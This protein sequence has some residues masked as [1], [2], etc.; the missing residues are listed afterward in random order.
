MSQVLNVLNLE[1]G[2]PSGS[3]SLG[4]G[5]SGSLA[6]SAPTIVFVQDLVNEVT[7]SVL[8][9]SGSSAGSGVVDEETNSSSSNSSSSP[10]RPLE[11]ESSKSSKRLKKS[12][13]AASGSSLITSAPGTGSKL[14]QRLGGILCCAVC[15][16]LPKSS[17]YQCTNGHLMCAGCFTHL[18]ADARIRDETAT[19]PNCRCVISKDACSR[20]LAVEKA[21]CELPGVC[22][23]CSQELP[24]SLLDKHTGD[25]CEERIVSCKYAPIGCGWNGPHHEAEF[26]AELCQHP[27]K[28]G[29]TVLLFL[30][31]QEK[32]AKEDKKLFD[33][34]FNLLSFEKITLNDLQFRPFRTDEYI[35]K[36]FYETARFS[37]FNLQWV[38][39]ARVTGHND[40][41]RDPTQ[42]CERQLSFQLSLKSKLATPM[43][44]HYMIL[45]GPFGDMKALPKILKHDFTESS[46]ESSFNRINLVSSA[47]CNRLLAAKVINFRLIMFQAAK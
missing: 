3:Q 7:A 17:V 46:L 36:L 20:N 22:P 39:K 33:S 24:R 45:K 21:V 42:S 4:S 10:K 8:Q 28:S 35:H 15:L 12:S 29:K 27:E 43:T 38:V 16:D 6:S 37:A 11:K 19:C 14:E 25:I 31:S 34:L 13:G 32:T 2:D 47:E 41:Q 40:D 9:A 23:F 30:Q 5:S 26:H 1:I 44:I 18:L